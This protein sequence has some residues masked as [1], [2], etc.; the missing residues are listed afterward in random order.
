MPTKREVKRAVKAVE[1]KL[2]PRKGLFRSKFVSQQE[3]EYALIVLIDAN[4]PETRDVIDR[5]FA[6]NTA[7]TETIVGHE[8]SGEVLESFIYKVC[9]SRSKHVGYVL[10]TIFDQH[11]VEHMNVDNVL[12]KLSANHTE[13]TDHAIELLMVKGGIER[14]SNLALTDT[15]FKVSTSPLGSKG[16]YRTHI[17]TPEVVQ[18]L[19]PIEVQDLLHKLANSKA[20]GAYAAIKQAFRNGAIQKFSQGTEALEN[21]IYKSAISRH[22]EGHLA[23]EHAFHYG[24]VE[25]FPQSQ[26]NSLLLK[27]VS[28]GQYS[29]I[30]VVAV[31]LR[32]GVVDKLSDDQINVL[33]TRLL[34]TKKSSAYKAVANAFRH[35]AIDKLSSEQIDEFMRVLATSRNIEAF[36]ALEEAIKNGAVDKISDG[37]LSILPVTLSAAGLPSADS[38]LRALLAHGGT[39][40]L[41][42]VNVPPSAGTS[43]KEQGPRLPGF[44]LSG[45]SS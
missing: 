37:V 31:S 4:T 41:E 2:V 26:L 39:E 14:A 23:A 3:F 1:K 22:R 13:N 7:I 10:G 6:V 16:R 40:R 24:A 33:L 43:P 21:I 25:I 44:G 35:G 38:A 8:L 27:M 30:G 19:R 42:R 5:A 34:E 20:Q 9:E 36:T 11:G 18:K 15:I 28:D 29:T 17:F 45:Y 12:G 32:H